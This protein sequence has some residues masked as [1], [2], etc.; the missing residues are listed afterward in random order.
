[1]SELTLLGFLFGSVIVSVAW[2]WGCTDRLQVAR[3]GFHSRA[4][5][6]I[7]LHNVQIGAGS[8]WKRSTNSPRVKRPRR[9]ADLPCASSAGFRK[10]WSYTY[11]S[12]HVFM[13]WGLLSSVTNSAIYIS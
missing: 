9:E 4:G 5:T 11:I 12:P 1:M 2:G 10:P 3:P 13:A 8:Q 6:K 7:F